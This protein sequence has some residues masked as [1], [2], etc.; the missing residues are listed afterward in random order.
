MDLPTLRRNVLQNTSFGARVAEEERQELS[1]YFVETD[2]WERIFSGEIDIVYGPKGS[3]KSAIYA[4]LLARRDELFDQGVLLVPAEQLLGSP[5]FE[6]I[7]ESD[8]T[9]TEAEFRNLWKLYF[10]TLIANEIRKYDIRDESSSQVIRYLE[11]EGLLPVEFSLRRAVRSTLDYVLRWLRPEAGE[12]TVHFDPST[13]SPIGMTGKITPGEPDSKQADRGAKSIDSLLQLADSALRATQFKVWLALDRL[14][15]A[16]SDSPELERNALRS[17]FRVYRDFA[18]FDNLFL[19]I[20]LRNDV[21]RRITEQGFSESSHITSAI[22]ITW[23]KQSLLNLVVRRALHSPL[24]REFYEV[25]EDDIL[26][27]FQLQRRLFYRIFP[28]Q[29]D[30]G[31]NKP[32]TFDWMLTRTK[33]GNDTTAPR[34]LIHLLS[35]ARDRQ[36]QRMDVGAGDSGGETLFDRTCLKEGLPEVSTTRFEQTLCAEYPQLKSWMT[37][38]E[39]ERTAQ[40]VTTL[41]RIWQVE[42]EHAA[43]TANELSDIGFFERRGTREAPEFWVPFLYRDALS[44]VQGAA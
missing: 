36:L 15:V 17:L 30:L 42:E 3:G 24:L 18:S 26:A 16:F 13:G 12:M 5:V 4:L 25:S 19:K 2:Q 8:P 38:L 21:W 34:E 37:G 7:A 27:E 31:V 29:V 11:D 23:D 35:A 39:G 43:K 9:T 32:E 41:A 20:F 10:L 44:L 6:G 14:D 1:N 22:T 28:A 33:D 40:N